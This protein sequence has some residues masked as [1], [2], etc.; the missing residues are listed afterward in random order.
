MILLTFV[1]AVLAGATAAIAGFGIGSLLT[2]L[3][4]ARV[5]TGL[6][7]AAVAIPHA[8]AS[9]LRAWRLRSAIDWSVLR[10]FGVLSAAG[11]LAGGL[12]YA[13]R[14]NRVLTAV[15]GVLLIATAVA[16]VTGWTSRWRPGGW[17]AHLLG[18]LSGLFGGVVGN[19][20]GLR[21]AALLTFGLAPVAFVATSTMTGLLVDAARTPI[22]LVRA[23]ESLLG[24]RDLVL[25]ATAGVVT[26]T[27]L[28]ERLLFGLSADR[29]RRVIAALIGLVGVLLL[30][31]AF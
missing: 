3:L 28:G 20:G 2:P 23:G 19:Q 9:A 18:V 11:G 8:V 13:R 30:V 6:A 31:Q 4:A 27:L 5:G 10:G 21:A 7:V 15:L 26:G 29:F 16:G 25:A 24:V 17:R 14:G 22:Y 12:L 1:V